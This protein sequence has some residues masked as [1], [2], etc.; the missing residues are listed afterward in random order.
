LLTDGRVSGEAAVL[1]LIKKNCQND[2]VN[3]V[4]S[5]GMGNGCSFRFTKDLS[6]DES[7]LFNPSESWDLGQMFRNQYVQ[8]YTIMTK[9]QFNN[10]IAA[11]FRSEYDPKAKKSIENV[12]GKD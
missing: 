5:F 3:K 12:Y 10:Q 7:S 6:Y 2:G 4:F 1:E 11:T 8:Q 9:E